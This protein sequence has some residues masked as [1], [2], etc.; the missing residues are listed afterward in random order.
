MV[1]ILLLTTKGF[2]TAVSLL[3]PLSLSID[4][5]LSLSLSLLIS[6]P[7]SLPPLLPRPLLADH[8]ALVKAPSARG[9]IDHRHLIYNSVG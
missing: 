9:G 1:P 7:S 5:S 8:R 3:P 6:L 2:V 4:L